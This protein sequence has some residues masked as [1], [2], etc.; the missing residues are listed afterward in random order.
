MVRD[1]EEAIVEAT[2]ADLVDELGFGCRVL[3]VEGG[4]VEDGR[5]EAFGH[6]DVCLT[7]TALDQ[8]G[9]L[10]LDCIVMLCYSRRWGIFNHSIYDLG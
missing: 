6:F 2:F 3:A 9:G 4:E 5:S 10:C 8:E 7:V 1:L